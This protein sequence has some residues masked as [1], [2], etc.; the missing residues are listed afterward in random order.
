M[1]LTAY[2]VSL[3]QCEAG[4]ENII[5]ALQKLAGRSMDDVLLTLTMGQA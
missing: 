3:V 4:I 5:E 2:I 1:G